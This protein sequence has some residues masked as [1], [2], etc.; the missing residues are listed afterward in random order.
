M[1]NPG[2]EPIPAEATA[3]HGITDAMVEGAPTF[4]EILPRL[5]EALAG[6]RIVIYNR[7]YDTGRLL[8]ELHLH[9]QAQGMVDFTKHPRYVARRHGAA[10]ARLTVDT[11]PA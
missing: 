1:L 6:R 5:A 7:D 10:Q 9:H 11:P 4:S 8:W 2:G 3:I